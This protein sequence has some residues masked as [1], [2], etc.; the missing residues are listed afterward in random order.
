MTDRTTRGTGA[1]TA[2]RAKLL[3]RGGDHHHHAIN[4]DAQTGAVKLELKD[5]QK[6]DVLL[7]AT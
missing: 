6:Q 4:V 5:A 7:V 3:F 2:F 1:W